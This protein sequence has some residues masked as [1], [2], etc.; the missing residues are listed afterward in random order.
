M[1]ERFLI[2]YP[3]FQFMNKRLIFIKFFIVGGFC[4]LLDLVLLYLL[5]DIFGI[6]YIYSGI[7]S[8]SIVSAIS[9]FLNK[10]ITFKDRNKNNTNQYLRYTAVILVGMTINN[11]FLF[12]FTDILGIYYIVSRIFSS[13][14][15]LIWNYSASKKFIF[16][17]KY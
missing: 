6:W 3:Y 8:F 7:I 4:G 17:I 16:K 1:T 11:F 13:L 9:F 12:A 14:I 2:K 15:A 10:N 5:T